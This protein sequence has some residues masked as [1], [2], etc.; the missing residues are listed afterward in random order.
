MIFLTVGS[1]LAKAGVG[2]FTDI[3][4]IGRSFIDGISARLIS[5]TDDWILLIPSALWNVRLISH[6]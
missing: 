6:L 4:D 1:G 5:A 2:V 3:H